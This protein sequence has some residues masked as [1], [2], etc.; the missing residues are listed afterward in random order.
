[1]SAHNTALFSLHFHTMLGAFL[2]TV[3]MRLW[4]TRLAELRPLAGTLARAVQAHR[5]EELAVRYASIH[6]LC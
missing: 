3:H 5:D 6:F 2:V 4:S 1:M